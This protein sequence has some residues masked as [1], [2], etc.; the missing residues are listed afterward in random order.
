V[1]QVRQIAEMG[2]G[3]MQMGEDRVLEVAREGFLQNVAESEV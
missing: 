1:R 3:T 2:L